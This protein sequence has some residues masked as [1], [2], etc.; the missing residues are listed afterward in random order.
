ME[1]LRE[2]KPEFQDTQN[3]GSQKYSQRTW[4]QIES[5]SRQDHKRDGVWGGPDCLCVCV[6]VGQGLSRPPVCKGMCMVCMCMDVQCVAH[7]HL[8][9]H[10]TMSMYV[11]AFVCMYVPVSVHEDTYYAFASCV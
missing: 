10:H 5:G 3:S 4:E 11:R 7:A 2:P 9:N 1:T 6:G 8:L